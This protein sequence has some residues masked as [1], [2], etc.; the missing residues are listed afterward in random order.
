MRRPVWL[1]GTLIVAGVASACGGGEVVVQAQLAGEGQEAR[2]ISDLVVRLL[3]YDRDVVF[4]S[5]Q[6]AAERPQPAI[7]DSL[8]TLQER[9]TE[10]QRDWNQLTARWNAVRDSLRGVRQRMDRLNRSSGEYRVLFNDFN[11]LESEEQRLNRQTEEAFG[12]FT[13]LQN[14]YV[15]SSQEVKIQRQNW[16]DEAF[17]SV[18]S[19]IDVRLDALGKDELVDT[20]SANGAAFFRSV[21]PGEWWVHGRLDQAYDELYWNVP[22][23]VERGERVEVVLSQENADVRAKL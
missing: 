13:E 3:P 7:P 20:T 5:L 17:A 19:V 14:R 9:V 8:V 18:D 1:I 22:I 10:A 16:G 23:V 2:P 4:D 12:E 21:S 15:A 11:A 6:E